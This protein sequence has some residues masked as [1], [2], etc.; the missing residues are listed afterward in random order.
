[1][2][3]VDLLIPILFYDLPFHN[4]I[5]VDVYPEIAGRR[6]NEAKASFNDDI[7]E[8]DRFGTRAM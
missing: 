7:G 4:I 8:K 1:M 3:G 2:R 6:S 5:I